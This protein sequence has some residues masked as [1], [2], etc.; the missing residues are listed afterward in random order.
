MQDK[1][2]FSYKI[3]E[4]DLTDVTFDS[5]SSDLGHS[6]PQ[7][8]TLYTTLQHLIANIKKLN[9]NDPPIENTPQEMDISEPPATYIFI[10]S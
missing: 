5:I 9:P 4:E 7:K 10:A 6:L 3:Q 8:N 1:R 2:R